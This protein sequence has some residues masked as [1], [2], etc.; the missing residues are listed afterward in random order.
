MSLTERLTQDG[1]KAPFVEDC[2]K[3]ID[4]EVADK[5]GLSGFALKAGYGMIK[6]M[7]PG[8][9]AETVGALLP[10]FAGA[11]DPMW[12]EAK[13][14]PD[15]VRHMESNR[16]RVADALLAI[17]DAR[18]QRTKMAAV[19]G[20]YEKLRGTAKRHVEDAVPRLAALLRRHDA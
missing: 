7:R 11:L 13:A 16:G 12:T 8:F 4:D 1:K 5:G 19:R 2:C 18:A 10:E 6:G 9:I 15:P 14:T 20:T 3:L 17:T